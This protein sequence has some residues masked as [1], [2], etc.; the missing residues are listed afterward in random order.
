MLKLKQ[1][2]GKESRISVR[3]TFFFMLIFLQAKKAEL[4]LKKIK[5]QQQTVSSQKSV[6]N[7]Y[8]SE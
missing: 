5:K 6:G 8:S 3:K 1:I 4:K 7:S 2:S